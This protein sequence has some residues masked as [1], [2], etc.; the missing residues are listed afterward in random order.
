MG[1]ELSSREKGQAAA[2]GR[3]GRTAGCLQEEG[4]HD[5]D[6]ELCGES[7]TKTNWRAHRGRG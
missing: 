7:T 4:H 3:D 1:D 5:K 6:R 2:A